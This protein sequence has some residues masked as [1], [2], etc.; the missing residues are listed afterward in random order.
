MHDTTM[1]EAAREALI[2]LWCQDGFKVPARHNRLVCHA[3]GH[4]TGYSVEHTARRSAL[5][6]LSIARCGIGFLKTLSLCSS[7]TS[8]MAGRR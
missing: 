8:R 4:G 5:R 2:D 1:R 7:M 3:Q 6:E